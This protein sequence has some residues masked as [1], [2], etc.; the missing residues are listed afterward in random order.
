MNIRPAIF[1]DVPD[2]LPMVA[3]VC[4]LHK[5]WDEAKYNF[6]P[7]PQDYY[8]KWLVA[9]TNNERSIFLVAEDKAQTGKKLVVFLIATVEREI[10]IYRLQEFAF[11][12]DLW[13]ETEY[14]QAGIAKQMVMETI[15]RFKQIE[16]KQIRLDTTYANEVARKLFSSCGFRI[17]TIEM[18]IEL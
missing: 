7:N 1:T 9:Q 3:S 2:I 8:H 18:L 14:R 10:P 17:S 4:A 16:I 11:V 5:T 15:A 12:H 13:V 6:K